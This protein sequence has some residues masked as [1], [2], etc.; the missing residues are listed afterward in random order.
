MDSTDLQSF[1]DDHHIQ[2]AIMPLGEHTLTVGDAARGSC[3]GCRSDHQVPGLPYRRHPPAGD[4][5]RSGT[6][7][8][9]KTGSL[10]RGDQEK[11]QVCQVRDNAF[12]LTGF[13]VGSMPP[14]GHKHKLRTLVDTAVT[15]LD[16]IYGGGWGCGCHDA[17]DDPGTP[18]CQPGRGG[19]L[20][21]VTSHPD[22]F[23]P[24]QAPA[25]QAPYRWTAACFNLSGSNEAAS[26][27]S[28]QVNLPSRGLISFA[29][30]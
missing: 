5:Q 22:S 29:G 20:F 2:A 3:R 9:Q 23:E 25:M 8:P 15:Q 27:S 6:S 13:V 10:S 16:I 11:G 26:A 24:Q 17:P 4:Q 12:A 28:S 14:F 1:I 7:G 21:R 30:R 19:G 18:G